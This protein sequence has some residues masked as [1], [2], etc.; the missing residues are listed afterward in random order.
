MDSDFDLLTSIGN[1]IRQ[2]L[3]SQDEA[4]K[5]SPFIWV[6]SL[7]PAA[8]GKLGARLVSAWCAAKGLRIDSSPDS[9]ADLVINGHR[10]EIKFSTLWRSGVYKFQQIRDQNYEYLVALGISP[11]E[12]HCWVI[13]KKI[14]ENYV[15]GHKPQHKGASGTD[16][17]WFEVDPNSPPGWLSGLGGSLDEAFVVLKGLSR[18]RR[19]MTRE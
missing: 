15:I 10:A 9:E 6:K 3:E 1:H 2:E 17:F 13:S 12:A 18:K 19:K 5:G 4:W 8:K 14:L 16:T 11:F 7:A